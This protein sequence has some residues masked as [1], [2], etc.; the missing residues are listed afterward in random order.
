MLKTSLDKLG[1]EAK[2]LE[3][4]IVARQKENL[5]QQKENVVQQKRFDAMVADI[6]KNATREV[7]VHA[8]LAQA[9]ER[10][11]TVS[12][13]KL[14][15]ECHRAACLEE[16]VT[17]LTSKMED[18]ESALGRKEAEI[19]GLKPVVDVKALTS[20]FEKLTLE[21]DALKCRSENI[22]QRYQRGDLVSPSFCLIGRLD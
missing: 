15:L 9:Q 14:K 6:H 3:K 11:S 21:H 12:L 2:R 4:E 22:L 1:K 8:Q 13:E 19:R 18:M 20:Q 16:Q 5:A 17:T 10:L 7:Q